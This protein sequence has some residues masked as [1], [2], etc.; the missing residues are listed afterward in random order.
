MMKSLSICIL[1]GLQLLLLVAT[2]AFVPP[3]RV[4]TTAGHCHQPWTNLFM[5]P[6]FDPQQ[7]KWIPATEEES[8]TVGYAPIRSLLRHG[9]K[10]FFVRVTQPDQ[11]DQAVLKFMATEKVERWEAQGNMDRFNENAQDWI[12]ERM[13]AKR[14]GYTLDYVTLNPKQVILSSIWAGIVFWFA[15]DLVQRYVL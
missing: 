3:H 10:A 8:A 13:E 14:K 5:V 9:P 15:N 7:Q 2:H 6:R 11:Y 1:V 4:G 12:F